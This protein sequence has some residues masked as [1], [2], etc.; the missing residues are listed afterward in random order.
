MKY[1]VWHTPRTGSNVLM[2]MLHQTKVAGVADY[3]NCGFP[4]GAQGPIERGDF[5]KKLHEYEDKQTTE[6]GIFACKLSWD[7]LAKLCQYIGVDY[8]Y[9]WLS[10]ID[11]HVY[12]YRVD[13]VAQAVSLYIASKRKYFSTTAL[14]NGVAIK[15][16][17][18]YNYD[19][20]AFR[21]MM[22]QR[23]ITAIQTYFEDFKIYPIKIS[24]ESMTRSVGSLRES[25][26]LILKAL[27]QDT[28]VLN[29]I[30]P[31]IQKQINPLKM[32]Y[33]DRWL[34]DWDE[35]KGNL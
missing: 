14:D 17:P 30:I 13:T 22:I 15:P 2:S 23:D 7:E 8:V 1:L 33:R 18:E 35:M 25:A 11:H 26:G 32:Q 16:T 9:D 12:L 20:I 19:E 5:L 34:L 29:D 6:N 24:F 4:L 21:H 3:I 31:Q 10:T 27:G 28:E